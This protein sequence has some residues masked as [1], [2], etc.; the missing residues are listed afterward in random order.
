MTNDPTV[1]QVVTGLT[2]GISYTVSGDYE[3]LTDRGGGL[4]TG[5]SFGVAI[6][7]VFHYEAPQSD[8]A[9][10]SF[11]FGFIATSSRMTLSISSQRNGTGVSYGIDN[12]VVQPTPSLAVVDDSTRLVFTWPTNTLGFTLQ[13]AS[14]CVA[15][16]WSAIT[17]TPSVTGSNYSVTILPT[18]ESRFF[19]LRR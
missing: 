10:H 2:V 7:G 18:W 14:N 15:G 1:S 4:P 3:K 17:N 6:D 11:G 9:W 13:S 5:L 19:R 16:S 12:I 8:W